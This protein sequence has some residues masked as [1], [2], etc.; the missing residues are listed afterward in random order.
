MA[1]QV[2]NKS[3]REVH[4]RESRRSKISKFKPRF[5]GDSFS[6]TLGTITT[7]IECVCFTGAEGWDDVQKLVPKT[8]RVLGGS[9][10]T[11]VPQGYWGHDRAVG[12]L[13]F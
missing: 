10:R 12:V 9:F 13:S 11:N 8:G 4:D 3:I 5:D 7:V 6:G 1:A 2:G